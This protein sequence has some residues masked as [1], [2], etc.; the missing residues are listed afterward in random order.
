MVAI[1]THVS[2]P[3]GAEHVHQHA[4]HDRHGAVADVRHRFAHDQLAVCIIGQDHSVRVLHAGIERSLV[5]GLRVGE[6]CWG[7]CRFAKPQ[8]LLGWRHSQQ[9]LYINDFTPAHQTVIAAGLDVEYEVIERVY[10]VLW[11]YRSV[12]GVN[13]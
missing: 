2:S 3:A 6:F 4:I 7:A 9:T 11:R 10:P 1:V 8:K 13:Q 12:K 5:K